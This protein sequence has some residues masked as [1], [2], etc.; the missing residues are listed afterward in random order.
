MYI[1]VSMYIHIHMC[2]CKGIYMLTVCVYI[3]KLSQYIYIFLCYL[4]NLFLTGQGVLH[5][6]ITAGS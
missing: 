1:Y 4:S 5:T 6:L 2:A 3:Y